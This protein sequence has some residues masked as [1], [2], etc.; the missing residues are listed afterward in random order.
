MKWPMLSI[1]FVV[2]LFPSTVIAQGTDPYFAIEENIA[3]SRR[4]ENGLYPKTT[5][6]PRTFLLFIKDRLDTKTISHEPYLAATTQDGVDVWIHATTVSEKPFREQV[7]HHQIIFNVRHT[8]CRRIGCDKN[9]EHRVWQIY[10]GEAFEVEDPEN[11][12]ICKLTGDRRGTKIV[13]YMTKSEIDTLTTRGFITR[14][15]RRHPKYMI[16]RR[17]AKTAETKCNEERDRNQLV[18]LKGDPEV[19]HLAIE[20]WQLGSVGDTNLLK[21]SQDY[22]GKQTKYS[23]FVYDVENTRTGEKSRFVSQVI[24]ACK[25]SGTVEEL[26]YIADVYLKDI[27]G[28]RMYPLSYKDHDTP[29]DLLK[30]TEAPYLFSVNSYKQYS[31]LIENLGVTFDDRALAGYFLSEYNR[32]C[33]SRYRENCKG[34]SYK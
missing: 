9:I 4:V 3:L 31:E 29:T 24:F 26:L 33:A 30:Y 27:S 11:C 18:P 17:E 34:H 13:G 12:S 16:V 23:F 6:I 8:L 14:A 5:Y 10:A 25:K 32:S 21:L 19:E 28:G 20:A 15:D 22:G 7:G 2:G 1:I